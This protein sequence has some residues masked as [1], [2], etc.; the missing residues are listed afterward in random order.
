MT[1]DYVELTAADLAH[2]WRERSL[3]EYVDEAVRLPLDEEDWATPEAALRSLLRRTW[4]DLQAA[5]GRA[6]RGVWSMECDW[7]VQRII[8]MT[9]LVGPVPWEEI[10]VDLLLDGIYERVHEAA[11]TPTPLTEDD[12][13]RAREVLERRRG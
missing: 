4:G 9:R 10:Q 2:R 3:A 13:A 7:L 11:G 5:R 1:D 8:G 12:R 6:N